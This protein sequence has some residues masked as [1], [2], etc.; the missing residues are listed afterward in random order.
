[1]L[2]ESIVSASHMLTPLW[3]EQ[4][5]KYFALDYR[6][7][8]VLT[9]LFNGLSGVAS[10]SDTTA[11]IIIGVCC[12]AL[13]LFFS[14]KKYGSMFTFSFL[15]RKKTISLY[16]S[17]NSERDFVIDIASNP[18][19]KF[20]YENQH[21]FVDVPR[22]M[23]SAV[24]KTGRDDC[25]YSFDKRYVLLQDG[26]YHISANA[27]L[28]FTITTN[29]THTE[30]KL[31]FRS[32]A[33][34]FQKG[35]E[36]SLFQVMTDGEKSR[37]DSEDCTIYSYPLGT[38]LGELSH[39]K[40]D[41]SAF[42]GYYNPKLDMLI[43]WI[44]SLNHPSKNNQPRQFSILCHGKSGT[45]KT[46]IVK[47]IA[48][49]T[50]RNIVLVNLF[51]VKKKR[52]LINLFYSADAFVDK[53][54]PYFSTINKTIFFIDEFDKVV[55]KLKMLLKENKSKKEEKLCL[56]LKT[57]EKTNE[58]SDNKKET[59]NRNE[60]D[61]DIDDLLEIFCGSYIP[62]KRMIVVACNDLESI[63]NEYPYLVRP[64][65]L[66]PIEF[67]YG[68]KALFMKVV[69]DYTDVELR[70]DDIPE[71]YRFVQSHLIEF[72]NYKIEVTREEILSELD[73]FGV[74]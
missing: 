73:M 72:L 28:V 31:S 27:N 67:D 9:L 20:L 41:L 48:E 64:G 35:D 68:D 46:A 25:N 8:T 36:N 24:M 63:T 23:T 66:T 16:W 22:W 29:T 1:M 39:R 18:I 32:F 5:V 61:W 69:E 59:E 44:N 12:V 71:D 42:F 30:K 51:E 54:L 65:R 49:Y 26:V 4:I 58:E 33:L 38:T 13:L 7:C 10:F 34:T 21:Y 53:G 6:Y 2:N 3:S 70:H 60:I 50:N 11:T 45:G 74:N 19:E 56:L 55:K 62:D 57:N 15:K 14:I 47:R 40:G 17:F 52:D 43:D 37:G